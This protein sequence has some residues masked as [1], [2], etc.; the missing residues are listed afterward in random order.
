MLEKRFVA[1]A[2][3][4]S[5]A[6]CSVAS[7]T[8]NM[9]IQLDAAGV[10]TAQDGQFHDVYRVTITNSDAVNDVTALSPLSFGP[11]PMDNG[12]NQTFADNDTF[13]VFGFA[14]DSFFV[15]P[16]GVTQLAVDVV[17]NGTT[18]AASY[19]L[20]G[21]DV[22]IPAASNAT[23]AI[24][25]V[26]AG[27][28][29]PV[30]AMG[31][32]VDQEVG[33]AVIYDG[34]TAA[35]VPIFF[36]GPVV[37]P[38][39]PLEQ[40]EAV[41]VDDLNVSFSPSIGA[42]GLGQLGASL[43][44]S[45]RLFEDP[46]TVDIR[47]NIDIAIQTDLL[48]DLSGDG[49]PLGVFTGGTLSMTD[50]ISQNII[51]G[52]IISLVLEDAID[53]Q[54]QDYLLGTGRLGNVTGAVG[55][56]SELEFILNIT[57]DTAMPTDFSASFTGM[58]LLGVPDMRVLGDFD[59]DGELDPDDIDLLLAAIGEADPDIIYDVT[60]EGNV[61][62]ADAD[63]WVH[64]LANTEYGDANLDGKVSLVDL[65][66]LGAG[67]NQSLGWGFGDFNG[68][69]ITS[70]LDLNTI[71]SNFGFDRDAAPGSVI[72]E[73]SAISLVVI[74]GLGLVRRRDGCHPA[75]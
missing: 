19:T 36:S 70:L 72:P 43:I 39:D 59:F 73:P 42:Y 16:P 13:P 66:R 24:L 18:L 54:G 71:G 17:D 58:S 6:F 47:D 55:N 28:A 22:L 64:D 38:P 51:T 60:G 9:E 8:L 4:F 3:V 44:T 69:G 32:V 37:D 10:F 53:D 35:E 1:T 40:Y 46:S 62:Q 68:D 57:P 14:P 31:W 52:D 12:V 11:F 34:S 61:N 74:G 41:V 49:S 33:G 27:A 5:M 56:T 67:F 7:A 65:N 2:F 25:S 30:T 15:L 45:V 48:V 29:D 50:V 75:I 21:T 63:A 26:P 20:M 23:V